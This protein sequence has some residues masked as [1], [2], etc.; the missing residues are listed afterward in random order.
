MKEGIHLT[1]QRTR[2]GGLADIL[3]T[4]YRFTKFNNNI[5]KSA[6]RFPKLKKYLMRITCFV[7]FVKNTMFNYFAEPSSSIRAD[8]IITASPFVIKAFDGLWNVDK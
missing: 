7:F 1:P 5:C 4:S 3:T 6:C 8:K 2:K